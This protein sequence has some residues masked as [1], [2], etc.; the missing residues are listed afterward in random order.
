MTAGWRSNTPTSPKAITAVNVQA[1]IDLAEKMENLPDS[2]GHG[3]LEVN[4]PDFSK[5]PVKLP[6]AMTGSLHVG[7]D[8]TLVGGKFGTALKGHVQA[9]SIPEQHVSVRGVDF[10]LESSK[11][12][13]RTP[14]P[15]R[16]PPARPRRRTIPF[17][18][19]CKRASPPTW[20]ASSTPITRL[21]ASSSRSPAMRPP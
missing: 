20:T 12:I 3:T 15:R 14:P 13:R 11:V 17:I 19:D 5:L 4:A 18:R 1:H 2:T 10:A 6:M 8:F 21:T 9:L 7:G 16:P